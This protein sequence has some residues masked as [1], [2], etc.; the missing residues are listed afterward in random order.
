M[1]NE[2]IMTFKRAVKAV[3]LLAA[4]L[5]AV[6][7]FAGTATYL[8]T[9]TASDVQIDGADFLDLGAGFGP[10]LVTYTGGLIVFETIDPG[11]FSGV[12]L[13]DSL[14]NAIELTGDG[15][16][17]VVIDSIDIA[18]MSA[19]ADFLGFYLDET[20]AN[21]SQVFFGI[22]PDGSGGW[23]AGLGGPDAVNTPGNQGPMTLPAT[24]VL[25]RTGAVITATVNGTDLPATVTLVDPAVAHFTRVY[26]NGGSSPIIRYT[27]IEVTG[28]GI[29]DVNQPMGPTATIARDQVVDW[30]FT[31]G[32][33]SWTVEFS[34]DVLNV[35]GADFS[36]TTLG[37]AVVGI[38]PTVTGGPASYTASIGG[39]TGASGTIILNFEV[40]D[41]VSVADGTPAEPASGGAQWFSNVVPAPAA[42][43][44]VLVFLG[45]VL[46]LAAAVAIRRKALKH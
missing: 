17:T 3:S 10:S 29:P 25:T 42:M 14:G 19:D 30:A 16:Y 36:L 7:A 45:I 41:V 13:P 40:G 44:W 22:T 31:N 8:G 21:T 4:V 37:D 20:G 38:A 35:D 33:G 28:V 5:L 46:A 18:D 6:P 1:G 23:N 34:E 2:K 32:S 43:G 9:H 11:V 15:T 26:F 24:V 12:Q 27:S 39:V